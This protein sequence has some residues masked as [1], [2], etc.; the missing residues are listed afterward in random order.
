MAY[1]AVIVPN[2]HT[3]RSTTLDRLE[4]F[5]QAG[6]KVVFAG[7]IPSLVDAL[8]SDRAAKLAGKCLKVKLAKQEV[9]EAVADCRDVVVRT[10]DGSETGSIMEQVRENGSSRYVFLCN[11]KPAD[12]IDNTQVRIRGD[13]NVTWL[14]TLSGNMQQLASKRD[15]DWTVID[16]SFAPYGHLLVSLEPGRKDGGISVARAK[17]ETPRNL[18]GAIPVT[19]SEPNVLLLDQAEWQINDKQWNKS[20]ELLRLQD[21]VKKELGLPLRSQC[22][23]WADKTPSP[24]AGTLRLKFSFESKIKV[25]KPLLALEDA[26]ETKISFDGK[27]VS[28]KTKGW[29]TDKAIKTVSLPGFKAGKHEIVLTKPVS[30]KTN[31]EWCY[32]LGDFGVKFEWKTGCLVEPVKSLKA[33]SWVDQGLPFY[34]GNVVYHYETE[35]NGKEAMLETPQFNAPVLS[36]SVDGKV[37][38]KIAFAP[39]ELALGRLDKG[40]HKIDITAYGSRVNAFGPIHNTGH[41]AGLKVGPNA[42]RTG[43][44]TW[45]Y[46]YKL[47]PAGL[48]TEPVI[49]VLSQK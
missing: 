14:D 11:T 28:S 3:I 6:G 30:R 44:L 8:P 36:V 18:S 33:G 32:L 46:D 35:G 17:R 25:S 31:I 23:P 20:E 38:G 43:G 49:S 2:L 16:W 29:F 41:T 48:I 4:Q 26:E 40:K 22:Q 39:F 34:A 10:K 45:S 15:G 47:R 1:D 9:L 27:E 5:A 12:A 42:W 19:L 21:I 24:V 7:G 13:W 37:A